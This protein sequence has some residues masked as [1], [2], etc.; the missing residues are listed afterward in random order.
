[1]GAD[2]RGEGGMWKREWG[3]GGR[4]GGRGREGE[5]EGER[6]EER[7]REK[8]GRGERGRGSERERDREREKEGGGERDRETDRQ[9]DRDTERETERE[10]KEGRDGGRERERGRERGRKREREKREEERD[11][12]RLAYRSHH[13][14]IWHERVAATEQF[15]RHRVCLFRSWTLTFRPP[16][17]SSITAGSLKG[18]SGRELIRN[19]DGVLDTSVTHETAWTVAVQAVGH[20]N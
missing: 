18:L 19:A 7:E 4:E 3:E 8:E 14:I 20:D 12:C 1:M 13:V 16:H 5:I 6:E 17:Y 9:T 15:H 10:T 2:G 11:V